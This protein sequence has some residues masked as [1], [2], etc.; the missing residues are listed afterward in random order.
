MASGHERV[1]VI[2]VWSEPG[3][4][5]SF[6]ARVVSLG[7]PGEPVEHVGVTTSV[8][9]V[10]HWLRTWLDDTGRPPGVVPGGDG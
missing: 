8:D 4:V 10:E 3:R 9:V 1:M 7:P 5:P 2:R 6:R